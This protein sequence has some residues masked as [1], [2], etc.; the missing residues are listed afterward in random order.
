MTGE[1]AQARQFALVAGEPSGDLLA[2]LLLD[3]LQR[4]FPQ[5]KP[6]GIGDV[7]LAVPDAD[8][9][10]VLFLLIGAVVSTALFGL[11]PALQATR[12]EPVR[13]IRTTIHGTE[14]VLDA[15]NRFGRPVLITSSSEVY[16]KGA[17]VPFHEDDDVVMGPTKTT[18][19]CYAYCKAI[20]A[21]RT[22][23]TTGSSRCGMPSYTESSSIFGSTMMKRTSSG[24]L[25]SS[26]DMIIVLTPTDLPEPVVPAISM[27]G[28]FARSR[29]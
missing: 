6:V 22:S 1:S 24:V 4:R 29:M 16:G 9:R 15:A 18:R 8:W 5:V 2:G 12:I 7:R 23:V 19:Y 13:T 10:V 14:V 20:D 21:L 3:G 17:K 11:T 26:I 27:C 25:F 28:A